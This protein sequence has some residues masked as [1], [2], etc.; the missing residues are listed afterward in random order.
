MKADSLDNAG[1]VKGKGKFKYRK[2]IAIEANEI[3]RLVYNL[4]VDFYQKKDF[5]N[6]FK[7]F[8]KSLVFYTVNSYKS[9]LKS[10]INEDSNFLYELLD[11]E[12]LPADPK[13]K[14]ANSPT[15]IDTSVIYNAAVCAYYGYFEKKNEEWEQTAL[16]FLK[17]YEKI[18]PKK[19]DATFM[20]MITS[21]YAEKA[22]TAK[23]IDALKEGFEKY[24]EDPTFLTQLVSLYVNKHDAKNALP[25]LEKALKMDSTKA[26]YWFAMGTFQDEMGNRDKAIIAYNNVL[27]YATRKED[28]YNANYNMGV[29]QFNQALELQNEADKEKN[30]NLFKEKSAIALEQFKKCIPFFEA[31][32]EN[33]IDDSKKRAALEALKPIY[34]RLGGAKLP[35][36][37]M[38][39]DKFKNVQD[40]LKN[41]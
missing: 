41:L 34:Y 31:C 3:K 10:N 19:D 2:D 20:Q 13:D 21:I 26:G 9:L 23:W 15:Y 40:E 18:S 7:Y 35:D 36:S 37:K 25:Y 14:M 38:Y 27:K 32:A 6:A 33:A 39:S 29:F 24:P 30:Y 22:D 8:N 16:K 1:D 28:I 4:G 5:E 11:I 17:G 12:R